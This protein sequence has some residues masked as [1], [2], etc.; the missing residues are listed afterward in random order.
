MAVSSSNPSPL[1]WKLICRVESHALSVMAP[2]V[3]A[4]FLDCGE[5]V[6][7]KASASSEKAASNNAVY[8]RNKLYCIGLMVPMC[9]TVRFLERGFV[10]S[11]IFMIDVARIKDREMGIGDFIFWGQD[12]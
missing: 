5:L 3:A 7:W 1:S 9:L 2:G 8:K 11:A 4:T 6:G 12:P 10:E